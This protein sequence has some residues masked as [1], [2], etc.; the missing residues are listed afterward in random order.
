MC[1]RDRETFLTRRS[2]N[3]ELH[4]ETLCARLRFMTQLMQETDKP[5][6]CG[7]FS[8]PSWYNGERGFGAFGTWTQDDSDTANVYATWTRDAARNPYCVGF[9][10]F[11]YRDQHITGRGSGY[12]PEAVYGEHY[13]FGLV[14]VAD[15]PKWDLVGVLR[16]ANLQAVTQRVQAAP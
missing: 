15:D 12:G 13:A 11:E 4:D 9:N 3:K 2:Y 6:F 5:V 7:E 1:I 10:W 14:D 8:F 16:T